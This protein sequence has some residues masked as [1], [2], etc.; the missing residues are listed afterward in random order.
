[1]VQNPGS[2]S[3]V[4][5]KRREQTSARVSFEEGA[6]R[7]VDQPGLRGVHRME[8]ASLGCLVLNPAAPR[9]KMDRTGQNFR[10]QPKRYL[11]HSRP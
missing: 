7:G 9:K 10:L 4:L 2:R 6:C 5:R 11:G 3:A 1:M 8:G